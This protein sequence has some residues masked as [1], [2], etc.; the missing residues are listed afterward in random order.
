MDFGVWDYNKYSHIDLIDKVF[1]NVR[2][3]NQPLAL[4]F[5]VCCYLPQVFHSG[6][7]S[8]KNNLRLLLR[9]QGIFSRVD[10]MAGESSAAPVY[11]QACL[12]VYIF[13]TSEVEAIPAKSDHE[14]RENSL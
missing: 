7:H 11:D 4:F 1:A 8:R 2:S 5:W 10:D 6:E 13:A 12:L 14:K 3:G 9:N